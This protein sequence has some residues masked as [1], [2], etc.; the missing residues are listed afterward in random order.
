MAGVLM[1]CVEIEAHAPGMRSAGHSVA[2]HHS[3][4]SLDSVSFA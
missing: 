2:P 1:G 4:S 3:S